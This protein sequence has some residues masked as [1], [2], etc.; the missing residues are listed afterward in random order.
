MIL[1]QHH[2][3]AVVFNGATI[4]MATAQMVLNQYQTF[5]RN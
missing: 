2:L 1:I 4:S 5:I 3:I